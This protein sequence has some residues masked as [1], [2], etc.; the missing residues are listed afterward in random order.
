MQEPSLLQ[1]PEDMAHLVRPP[2]REGVH[3]NAFTGLHSISPQHESST[4]SS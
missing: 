4:L 1:L 3:G 2:D